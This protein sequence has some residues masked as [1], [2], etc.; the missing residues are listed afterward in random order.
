MQLKSLMK[1]INFNKMCLEKICLR[2]IRGRENEVCCGCSTLVGVYLVCIMN[3]ILLAS[4][5]L[6]FVRMLKY[7]LDAAIFLTIGV[8]VLR[9]FF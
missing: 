5:V 3:W 4:A 1:I 9:V 8:A 6:N 2:H 7:G